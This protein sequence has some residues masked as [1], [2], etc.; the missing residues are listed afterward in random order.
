LI[1][2][3]ITINV[4]SVLLVLLLAVLGRSWRPPRGSPVR[5]LAQVEGQVLVLFP[6][7][8]L[9]PHRYDKQND[10]VK[11]QNGREHGKVKQAGRGHQ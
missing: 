5:L 10:P 8:D 4:A 9:S 1:T 2:S 3:K 6:H 11:N 7:E